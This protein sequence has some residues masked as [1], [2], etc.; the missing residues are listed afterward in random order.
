MGIIGHN[1]VIVMEVESD[2]GNM[3]LEEYLKYEFEKERKLWRSIDKYYELPHLNPCFQS[4]QLHTKYDYESPNE[5]DEVDIDSIK[6]VIN[7]LFKMGAENLKGMKQEEAWVEY[8]DEEEY[9]LDGLSMSRRKSDDVGSVTFSRAEKEKEGVKQPLTSQAIHITPIDDA[10]ILVL[11]ELL[12]EFNDEP[13]SN[14]LTTED[15]ECNPMRDME[16]LR[17][18]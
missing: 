11:V 3:T 2:I 17:K 5:D 15:D 7:D 4:P 1:Y 16:E 14:S 13:L 12:K 6:K 9:E 8:C 10:T 18:C